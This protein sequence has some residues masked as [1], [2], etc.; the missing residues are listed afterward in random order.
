MSVSRLVGWL[1]GVN[2]SCQ[3]KYGYIRD[4]P[5]VGTS[6]RPSF[7]KKFGLRYSRICAEKGR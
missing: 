5:S 3:P 1:V 7:H 4:D 2:V 6:V